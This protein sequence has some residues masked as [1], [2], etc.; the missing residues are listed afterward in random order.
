MPGENPV[1]ILSCVAIP[2]GQAR[3]A[4]IRQIAESAEYPLPGTGNVMPGSMDWGRIMK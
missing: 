4:G 2:Q 3:G 1:I